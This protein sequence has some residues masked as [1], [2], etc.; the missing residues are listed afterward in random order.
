MTYL[1]ILVGTFAGMY[2]LWLLYLAVMSL[3]RAKK[4]NKLTK[5]AYLLALPILYA[6]YLTDF[7]VNVI[8]CTV[9]FLEPPKELLV[10]A[11][12]SRHK[13]EGHGYRKFI[14]TW[15]CVNLLDGFD[16][17]GCHCV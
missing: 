17:K 16:P 3:F 12:V 5:P 9:L 7:L 11:R 2:L 14:A 6:G 4:E 10:T 13:K 8:I 15:I 1:Y